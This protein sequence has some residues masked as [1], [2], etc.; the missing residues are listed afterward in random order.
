VH[1][2]KRP[3][4]VVDEFYGSPAV[5]NDHVYFMTRYGTYCLGGKDKPAASPAAAEATASVG[6]TAGDGKPRLLIVPGD[7]TVRPG[8]PVAFTARLLDADG[9]GFKPVKAE[10]SVKGI[11]GTMSPEGAFRVAPEP[12][13]A[14]G[15]VTAKAEGIEA[16]ARL[17]VAPAPP[18]TE[19][20]ESYEPGSVPPGWVGVG[21]KTEIAERDGSKVL[22]KLSKKEFPSPPFM[23]VYA[24]MGLPI[25]DGCTVQCDM[26]GTPRGERFRP[27]MGL[28]ALRY[29][30]TIQGIGKNVRL[31]SW[32]SIPRLRTELPFEFAPDKWYTMKLDVAVEETQAK[33]RGKVWPRGEAEPEAWTIEVTDPTPNREGAVALYAYSPGTTPKSDGPEVYFD[34]LKV[35]PH[36]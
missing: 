28:V 6:A 2:F 12:Q 11:K 10:W 34:N 29:E 31:E 24:F 8:E 21:R 17:R 22:R 13:F 33:V 9:P 4:E 18:F 27:D 14:A 16:T 1:E 5:A 19:D 35:T 36:E 3:D 20:F 32:G 26:L 15:I 7:L 25:P 30:L 23:R